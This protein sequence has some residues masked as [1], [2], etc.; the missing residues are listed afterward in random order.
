[1]VMAPA[2]ANPRAIARPIPLV[3]PSTTATR[4]LRENSS[5]AFI[6]VTLKYTTR[7]RQS[8][9]IQVQFLTLQREGWDEP[10]VLSDGYTI[11]LKGAGF[12]DL[13]SVISGGA[14]ALDRVSRW[15]Y[16]PPGS[17]R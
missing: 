12:D 15:L 8:R 7:Q 6:G 17:E 16:R 14:D 10:G 13:L 5:S 11:G 3:P 1:M 9:R 2:C 4:F